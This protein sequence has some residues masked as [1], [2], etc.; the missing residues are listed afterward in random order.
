MKI[1][2]S[3]SRRYIYSYRWY[4]FIV[5]CSECSLKCNVDF[6]TKLRTLFPTIPHKKIDDILPN[7]NGVFRWLHVT[8]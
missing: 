1:A 8:E 2:V 3:E 4:T 6:K 7:E 5:G